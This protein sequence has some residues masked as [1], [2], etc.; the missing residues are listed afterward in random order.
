MNYYNEIK[1]YLLKCEIYDKTKDYLKEQNKV[2]V[3]FK[4]GGLLNNAKKE[5]GKHHKNIGHYPKGRII[6]IY[7]IFVHGGNNN[8]YLGDSARQEEKLGEIRGN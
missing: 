5:Y 1:E 3:Y 2:N 6:F 7:G 8:I 4:I